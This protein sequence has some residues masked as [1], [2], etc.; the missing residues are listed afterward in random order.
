MTR[1][2][3]PVVVP[4]QA[5]VVA[6]GLCAAG[7]HATAATAHTRLARASLLAA[8]FLGWSVAVGCST[9]RADVNC[10]NCPC[11]DYVAKGSPGLVDDLNDGNG[12][13]LENDGRRGGWY[14][15]NDGT[16]IQTPAGAPPGPPY[17]CE[18]ET[19]VPT[20]GQACTSGS[21]FTSWGA[22]LGVGL[23]SGADCVSCKYDAT[24]YS[25]VRF[26]IS[27]SVVGS[28]RFMVVTTA[29]HNV[30]WGGTCAD[31]KVCAD[32]YGTNVTITTQP[33][34]VE[35]PWTI[36]RQSGWGTPV[37]FNVRE[38]NNLQ[39]EVDRNTTA[40]VVSFDSLCVDDVSFY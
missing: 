24:A 7:S 6:T 5:R 2:E 23:L 3:E 18:P 12:Y 19:F 8:A 4:I 39:W 37:L 26:T 15:Y 11:S 14:T 1:P 30:R 21:G 25:G 38:L 29:T 16:G 27:G 40:P 28:V 20:N 32:N 34:V 36:L 31:D 10:P 13:I 33:Q 22:G 17:V 35:V 9:G